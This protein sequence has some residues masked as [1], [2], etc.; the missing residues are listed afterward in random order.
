MTFSIWPPCLKSEWHSVSSFSYPKA[1]IIQTVSA[2]HVSFSGDDQR[3]KVNLG[4]WTIGQIT[5]QDNALH[6][7]PIIY[8]ALLPISGNYHVHFTFFIFKD[9]ASPNCVSIVTALVSDLMIFH[10]HKKYTQI[11]KIWQNISWPSNSESHQYY[12]RKMWVK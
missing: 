2:P 1:V 4:W 9:V 3:V 10:N 5:N 11:H 7:K 12:I 8:S 6:H